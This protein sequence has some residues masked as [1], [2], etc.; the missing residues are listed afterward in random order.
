M[1]EDNSNV[2]A[3]IFVH[4]LKQVEVDKKRKGL[5]NLLGDLE[6]N[7]LRI[8][9]IVRSL[10]VK[11]FLEVALQGMQVPNAEDGFKE[12]NAQVQL[13]WSYYLEPLL[14]MSLPALLTRYS[15][16]ELVDH[17]LLELQE[18]LVREGLS[19]SDF[20]IN[21]YRNAIESIVQF[22]RYKSKR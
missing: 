8:K 16:T 9:R 20:D 3:A 4:A 18:K 1:S 21:Q 2:S 12:R 22:G 15:D 5:K 11:S 6:E 14:N 7:E 19:E 17:A 13:L 10:S